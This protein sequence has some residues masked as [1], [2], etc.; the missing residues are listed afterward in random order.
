M[1]EYS[2]LNDPS[3]NEVL[4]AFSANFVQRRLMSAS[5]YSKLNDP[6]LNEVLHEFSVNFVGVRLMSASEA[7]CVLD[8]FV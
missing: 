2:K 3:L 7:Q 8:D 6:P 1:S 4:H 5:E